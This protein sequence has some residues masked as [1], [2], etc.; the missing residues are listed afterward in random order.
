[1]SQLTVKQKRVLRFLEDFNSSKGFMPSLR[2][3]QEGI[4][5]RSPSAVLAHLLP[6]EKKGYIRRFRGAS[7]AISLV[8]E[9]QTAEPPKPM[10]TLPPR[11]WTM[12]AVRG[13]IQVDL[14]VSSLS[15][16]EARRLALALSAWADAAASS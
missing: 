16:V 8:R 7:R 4:G 9:S 3:I 12:R 1:M 14:H 6:L 2:E 13:R 15:V 5:V 11:Q 10:P